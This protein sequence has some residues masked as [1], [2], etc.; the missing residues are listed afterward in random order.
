MDTV[1]GNTVV[2]ESALSKAVARLRKALEDDPWAP[3]H[4]ETVHSKGY[5]FVAE[6]EETE[7]ETASPSKNSLRSVATRF[8]IRATMA[9]P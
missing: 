4:I 7:P 8:R 6:V 2:S 5:R 1:W 9:P 3:R